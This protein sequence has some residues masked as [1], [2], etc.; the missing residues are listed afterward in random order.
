MKLQNTGRIAFRRFYASEAPTP[1]PG[2]LRRTFRWAWR[3]TYLSVAGILGYTAYV[4]YLDRNPPAQVEPD[5]TKKTLV[6]LG[7][8][9]PKIAL[10]DYTR[11]II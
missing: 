1:K 10:P 2:R 11:S 3:L 6:I 9:Y 7:A 4:V 8:S 5:P